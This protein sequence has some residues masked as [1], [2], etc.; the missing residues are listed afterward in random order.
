MC[1]STQQFHFENMFLFHMNKLDF[2][3]KMII[4]LTTTDQK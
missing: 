4:F 3:S 1:N 2:I